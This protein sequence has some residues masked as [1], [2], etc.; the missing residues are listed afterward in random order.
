M[1]KEPIGQL[2]HIGIAVRNLTE[3][4]KFFEDIL[5]AR[6]LYES[7]NPGA[8]YKLC[9]LDLEGLTIELLE[10]LGDG[11]F[12]H[13]FLAKRGEGLHHLTFN[14]PQCRNKVQELKSQGVRVVDEVQWSPTSYEAFISP[15][16]A[17]GVL[18]QLGSGYPT[19][20]DES[21]WQKP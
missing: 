12:L 1:A 20:A 9:E 11:S 18:I 5:G 13:K 15:R 8:G 21:T 16:S 14:V 2:D 7:E 3:A 19:L 6:L 4:R 10:P 17:H